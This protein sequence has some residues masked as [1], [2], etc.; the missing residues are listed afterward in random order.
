MNPVF[1]LPGYRII[2]GSGLDRSRLVKVL[3]RTYQE[4]APGCSLIHVAK[5]VDQFF[6]KETPLWWVEPEPLA[7]E[8]EP[9][10]LP[11]R[12]VHHPVG[13]LWLGNAVDPIVGD[14]YTHIFLLYVEPQ[15][16]RQGIGSALLRFAED[17]ARMRGDRQLGLQVFLAN[18]PA[19]DLYLRSGFHG[20][21][22]IMNKPLL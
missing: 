17:W 6:S 5:T 4:F 13:C 18:Q 20:Q 10:R 15:Q 22:L 12:T 7:H 3:Q 11:G 1:F 21:S 14:R 8:P 19:M 9:V 16:R 2:S